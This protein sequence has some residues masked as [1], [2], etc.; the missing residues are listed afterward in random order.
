MFVLFCSYTN[1][2]AAPHQLQFSYPVQ[3]QREGDG[4]ERLRECTGPVQREEGREGAE[5]AETSQYIYKTP[6]LCEMGFWKGRTHESILTP[7][8]DLY[9]PFVSPLTVVGLM[10]DWK[11]LRSG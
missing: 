9:I 5:R 2:F 7:T 4:E 11:S 8:P 10:M 6:A 3:E 1:V